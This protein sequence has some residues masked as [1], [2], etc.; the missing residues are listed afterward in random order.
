[1]I[2]V[3]TTQRTAEWHQARIGKLTGSRAC[4][5]LAT[6]KSGE[7]AARRD[8]RLQLVCERLTGES[9]E[10]TYINAA[11]QRGIDKEADAFAAYE[12]QTGEVA[13]PVGFLAH[14]TIQAGC[15]PDGEV[16]GFRG[17]LELKC[18]KTATH[19]GYVRSGKVPS[20][21]MPQV[22]HNLW[23]SGADWCDFFSFDD[24]LPEA[25]RCFRVR[26][27][28]SEL[29]LVGYENTVKAFLAEVDRDVQE[30]TKLAAVAA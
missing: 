7:A 11:M 30:L 26:V 13:S 5:M 2:I 21:H 6:I 24:R 14:D 8:L 16:D 22:I 25:L 29:D 15:S 9:Q 20:T 19:I 4:D 17:L 18:P 28:A 3:T 23:L 10:D 27:L 1:M 12:A